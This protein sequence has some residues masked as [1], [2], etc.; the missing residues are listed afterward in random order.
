MTALSR[1]PE[2]NYC[3]RCGHPLEDREAY[4][5][6][7]RACPACDLIV[8]R[9]L[10]VAAG[11]LVECDGE[12]LLVRRR[13]SPRRGKWSLPAGFVDFEED[14]T[15]AAV[16]EC[17]EE[18]GLQVEITGLLEVIAGR[19][20]TRGADIVI[21][22]AAR[23]VGGELQPSDDVDQA[24]FFAPGELPPLAFRATEVAVRRWRKRLGE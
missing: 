19:E 6:L 15:D 14:P 9:E 10:K 17:R 8:F 4:G 21:V 20:H 23:P 18:T 2:L 3:P 1:T 24:A 7:R 16:R 12:V 5:R 22:Y 13:F 11:V